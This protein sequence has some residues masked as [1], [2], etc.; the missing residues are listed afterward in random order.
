MA[1]LVIDESTGWPFV[2]TS[3]VYDIVDSTSDRA[4]ELVREGRLR[5]PLAVWART[6]IQGRGRGTNEWWSDGGSLTFTI[7]IDPEAHGLTAANEPTLALATGVAIIEALNDLELGHPSL[8][9]RW[10]NDLEANGRKLG[11]ILP[12]RLETKFGRRILVGIG[13]NVQTNLVAAPAEVRAMA[14]SLK[15]LQA[16]LIDDDISGRLIPAILSRFGAAVQRLAAGDPSLSSQ[17]DRL[18]LLRD[19]WV[20]IDLGLNQVA[21]RGEGIDQQGALCLHDG[22]KPHRIFGGRVV[23][24]MSSD[25]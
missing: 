13:L 20:C 2:N 17:W 1:V 8:G 12:E 18:D 25:C 19:T 7:A 14:T 11:G 24:D 16:K 6:Q 21:G 9:I 3:V 23:R 4:A 22:R 10:P 15:A 5:L